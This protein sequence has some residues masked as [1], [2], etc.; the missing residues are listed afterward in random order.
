MA[1]TLSAL[2]SGRALPS[3]SSS[4]TDFCYRLSKPKGYSA[5]GKIR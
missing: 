5:A 4:G 1:I 3:E 2:L